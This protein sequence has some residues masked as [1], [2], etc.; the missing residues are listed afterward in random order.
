[1]TKSQEV[2]N[3]NRGAIPKRPKLP[4]QSSLEL[5]PTSTNEDSENVDVEA[6]TDPDDTVENSRQN[7]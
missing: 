3:V 1:M 2:E 7:R 5:Q 4:K 6:V